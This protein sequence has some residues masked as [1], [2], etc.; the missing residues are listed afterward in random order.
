MNS[1]GNEVDAQAEEQQREEESRHADVRLLLVVRQAVHVQQVQ[2]AGEA[3]RHPAGQHE[4]VGE[5]L[6]RREDAKFGGAE[7]L[8]GRGQFQEAHHHLHAVEPP[9]GLGQRLQQPGHERQHEERRRE[10]GRERQPAEDFLRGRHHDQAP[11]AASAA[12]MPANPPR[13]GATQVKLMT[14]NA[15]APKIVP[16]TPPCDCFAWSRFGP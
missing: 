6:G 12:E 14:V 13:N 7:E 8:Q 11:A 4:V 2:P 3:D 5:V 1:A 15:S 9:A 16:I 10:R